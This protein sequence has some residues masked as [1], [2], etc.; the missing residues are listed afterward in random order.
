MKT[1]NWREITV[2][3]LKFNAALWVINGVAAVVICASGSSFQQLINSAFCSKMALLETGVA[4][5]VGGFIA[6]SGS[7]SAS[8]AKELVLKSNENWSIEKLR[9][10]EKRANKYFLLALILFAESL[11]ISLFGY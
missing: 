10:G 1:V 5:V 11:L 3:Q 8:K 4:L 9:A 7:V 2:W 6:F